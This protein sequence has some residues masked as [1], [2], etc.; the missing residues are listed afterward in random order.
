MNTLRIKHRGF[1]LIE[2]LVAIAIIGVLVGLLLPA[3]QQAREAARRT[4]CGN[5]LKQM[6]LAIHN[7][8]STNAKGANARFPA[9]TTLYTN[10]TKNSDMNNMGT[11]S[12]RTNQCY[13]WLVF[14]LPYAEEDTVYQEIETRSTNSGTQDKFSAPF[15]TAARD[16]ARTTNLSFAI[17][18]SWENGVATS[19]Q[20]TSAGVQTTLS[21]PEAYASRNGRLTP[22]G[23]TNY[24]MNLGRRYWQASMVGHSTNKGTSWRDSRLGMS[25]GAYLGTPVDNGLVGFNEF[26]DGLSSTICLVE[27]AT[28][29]EWTQF[30][31]GFATWLSGTDSEAQATRHFRL[32]DQTWKRNYHGGSSAHT[33]DIF[34][35]LMCDGSTR[36]LSE[37]VDQNAYIASVCRNDGS[38]AKLD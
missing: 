23:A 19:L 17:C 24:R 30:A 7:F 9:M 28:A 12:G 4:S 10:G 29:T 8:A 37:S 21:A 18:P 3:V 35:V 15:Q 32:S 2:L 1:T 14:I 11:D 6:G 27:N 16:Y 34:G 5:N 20:Q 25:G 26:L 33:G 13:S 31:H 22:G 38:T 36:F